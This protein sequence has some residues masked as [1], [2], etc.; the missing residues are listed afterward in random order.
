MSWFAHL[1]R[2]SPKT[3]A[4]KALKYAQESY[5]VP[6]ERPKTSWISMFEKQLQDIGLSWEEATTKAED[7]NE[8]KSFVQEKYF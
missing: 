1:M 8:W 4:R 6:R 2:M 5:P 7:R 3:P